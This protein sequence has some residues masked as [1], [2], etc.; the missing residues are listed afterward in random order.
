MVSA[1]KVGG[2]RLHALA[3]QGVEVE[4]AARPVTVYRFE[5]VPR[6]STPGVFRVEVEC[7]SG[8]YIR[9]LAAD[10]GTAA[11]RRGP[12]AQPPAHPD[13]LVRP[14]TTPGWSTT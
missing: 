6:R 13:R 14:S 4:R 12:P 1:V 3:R 9:V 10:L 2:R 7:S 8:T 11:R 5:V